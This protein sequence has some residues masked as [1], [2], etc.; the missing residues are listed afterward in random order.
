LFGFVG[1]CVLLYFVGNVLCLLCIVGMLVGCVV[2]WSVGC[3]GGWFIVLWLL[4]VC[5]VLGMLWF[6]WIG[7]VVCV[8]LCFCFVV[9]VW[10]GCFVVVCGGSWC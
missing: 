8:W 6:V 7:G 1:G 9:L 4:F 10:V 5:V 2:G 3:S